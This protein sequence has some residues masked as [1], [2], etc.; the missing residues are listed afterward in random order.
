MS[1]IKFNNREL[2]NLEL[3]DLHYVDGL[4]DGNG[5]QD[6]PEISKSCFEVEPF[7]IPIVVFWK[8]VLPQKEHLK[9]DRKV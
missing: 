2:F 5:E 8:L 3:V 1:V 7:S 4:A 6:G 9:E